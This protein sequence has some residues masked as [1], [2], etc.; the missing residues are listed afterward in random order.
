VVFGVCEVEV[1]DVVW[2]G[3]VGEDD[4]VEV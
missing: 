3:I 4:V 1:F 2:F